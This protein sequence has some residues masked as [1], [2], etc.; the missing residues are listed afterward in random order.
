[1]RSLVLA[2]SL[3]IPAQAFALSCVEPTVASSYAA[4]TTSEDSF[5]LSTGTLTFDVS[6]LPRSKGL[7][8]KPANRTRIPAT[9][10]GNAFLGQGFDQPFETNVELV[11]ECVLSWC[12]SIEPGVEHLL[13][14]REG[15]ASYELSLPA[16][17]GTTFA[18]P[19]PEMLNEVKTCFSEGNCSAETN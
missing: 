3:L 8:D 13:F 14:L 10:K 16:C 2:A 1:M 12:G 17:G 6:L 4:A 15:K 7:G 5:L 18:N 19:T 11:V 9:V